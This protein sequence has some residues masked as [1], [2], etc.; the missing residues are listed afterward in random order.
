VIVAI[1][2]DSRV[3]VPEAISWPSMTSRDN[4]VA[5]QSKVMPQNWAHSLSR[6]QEDAPESTRA[7]FSKQQPGERIK[8]TGTW[9]PR[10]G[11]EGTFTEEELRQG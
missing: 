11:V 8:V 1:G 7:I 4:G 2:S 5:W 10:T 3:M 9:K 6:K